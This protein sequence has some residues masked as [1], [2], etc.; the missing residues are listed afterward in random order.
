[1]PSPRDK[2]QYHSLLND[3]D[4]GSHLETIHTYS[5]QR[6]WH[7]VNIYVSAILFFIIGIILVAGLSISLIQLRSILSQIQDQLPTHKSVSVVPISPLPT[8]D[9]MANKSKPTRKEFGHCGHSI[10]EARALG[11]IFDPMS[12]AWQRPECY[13]T[14]LVNDFLAAYDWHFFPNA[15]P[16]PSEELPHE[17]GCVATILVS[18]GHGHGTCTIA[19]THGESLK[20]H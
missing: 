8:P 18:L 13:N 7:S 3:S 12:S 4:S 10:K 16:R 5:K 17:N 19:R 6:P 9:T 20:L 11:C 14:E 1:M 15:E 2:D